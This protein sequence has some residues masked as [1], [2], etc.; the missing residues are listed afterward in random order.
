M[1][2][3]KNIDIKITHPYKYKVIEKKIIL[4]PFQNKCHFNKK[5]F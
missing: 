5:L 4:I 2:W 1:Y 3:K